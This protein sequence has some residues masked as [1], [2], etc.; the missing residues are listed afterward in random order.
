LIAL[1]LASYPMLR[2][3]ECAICGPGQVIRIKAEAFKA[4]GLSWSSLGA[5]SA[6]SKYNELPD[7]A[8]Y[9]SHRAYQEALVFG[10]PY[11]FPSLGERITISE[12]HDYRDGSNNRRILKTYRVV[13]QF[14]ASWLE[15][16]L[17]GAAPGSVAA[18]L[19]DQQ[20]A[21]PVV[22]VPADIL[23]GVGVA[24]GGLGTLLAV[25]FL[26]TL[27]FPGCFYLTPTLLYAT[28]SLTL[29]RH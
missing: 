8:G 2:L 28:R 15:R 7:L 19:I 23:G 21:A 17:R 24:A 20:V 4:D 14:K 25:I 11:R 13:K 3:S 9:L 26:S 10:R 27:L 18:L 6:G 29:R 12:Y 1:V 22:V 16:S 5:L